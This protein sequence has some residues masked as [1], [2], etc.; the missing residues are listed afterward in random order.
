LDRVL[1]Y[2]TMAE[3]NRFFHPYRFVARIG[4]GYAAPR[5]PDKESGSK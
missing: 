3:E 5:H 4:R 1:I 2:A